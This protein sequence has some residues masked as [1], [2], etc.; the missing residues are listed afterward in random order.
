MSLQGR[1][2]EQLQQI[3]PLAVSLALEDTGDIYH[4]AK[5]V[6]DVTLTTFL[7]IFLS[8]VMALIVLVI[9]LDS[10]GPVIFSQER[11]GAKRWKR[12]G[13]SYWRW[14]LFT[15]YKFRTMVH[16]ANPTV[17]Q[18]YV[19]AF[20]KG[21]VKPSNGIEVKYKL[22]NDTRV[23]HVGKVLRKLSLDELPQLINILRGEMSLVG[24]RPDVPYAVKHYQPWHY[25]R[26]A[27]LPGLTGLWQTKGRSNVTFD[28]MVRYDIDYIRSQSLLLDLKILILTVP[29]IFSGKGAV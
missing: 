2:L 21:T 8:P 18:D 25:E 26:L 6:M 27:T 29:A 22:N 3:D 7:L 20:V 14:N 15:C 12:D 11:V 28:K 13:C 10:R 5:R 24:P 16:D 4:I 23:T 1:S 17:H 9:V 19:E